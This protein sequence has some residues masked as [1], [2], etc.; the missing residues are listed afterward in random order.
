MEEN[1]AEQLTPRVS[2]ILVSFNDAASLRRALQALEASSARET[3]EVVVVDSGS[4]DDCPRMDAEFPSITLLRLPRNF[5]LVRAL[6]IGMRTAKG[7]YY[8]FLTPEIEVSRDAVARLAAV[9]DGSPQAAAVCPLVAGEGGEVVSRLHPLPLP[10][11]LQ[12]AWQSGELA[13]WT[14]PGAVQEPVEVDYFKPPVFMIR[15]YFLKGL[16]YIDE[17]Y[18]TAWWDLEI[19][20][21]IVKASKKVLLVADARVTA[22]A[23]TN[24][25]RW[26]AAVRGLLAAD[27]ALGAAL[28]CSKHYGWFQG[29]T[30]RFRATL[31]ALGGVLGLRDAGCRW[32]TLRYLVSGQKFDGSL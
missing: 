32:A 23:G 18:G 8:F 17:R 24:V 4:S 25:S 26:P 12:R 21:Q 2:V 20:A 11:E 29:A 14:A 19:A 30:F 10:A 16:R 6:N 27:R 28:W 3:F 13:G 9:L 5:G 31:R 7:D 1:Q 15:S 22:H